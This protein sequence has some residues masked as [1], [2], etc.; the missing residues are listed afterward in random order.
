LYSD[1]LQIYPTSRAIREKK[2]EFLESSSFLPKMITIADFESR[3]VVTSGKIVDNIQ[4]A[5]FLK[6]AANFN[7][8]K[9][10]KVDTSLIKFYSH[11][12]EFFKFFQELAFENVDIKDLYLA[13]SYAWFDKDLDILD[14]LL[15]RYKNIINEKGFTDKIFLPK[16][17]K[18]NIG[19]LN[20]F[21][22]FFLELDGFLTKFELELF[23]KISEVK[24]FI[25]KI[26][27]NDFN[28]KVQDNFKELG[29]ILPNNSEI[30]FNLSTK[31]ILSKV[32]KD[33]KLNSEVI[34]CSEHLEQIAIAFSKIEDMIKGGIKPEKIAIVTPDES[35]A[36]A[37]KKLDR[38]NNINLAMGISYKNHYSFIV[39]KQLQDYLIGNSV[40]KDFLNRA[41]FNLDS[42]NSLSSV[43]DI[44]E[45]FDVLSKLNLP[46]Y[47][48]ENFSRELESLSL[49]QTFFKFKKVFSSYRFSFKD[50]LFLWID[51]IKEHSLDDISGG[52][53]TVLGV[54]ET[55]G[56]KFDGVV[57]LDFNDGIVPSISTKDRFLN[58]SVRLNANLPT[59]SDREN[60]QKNYY[61]KLL[62][63]AKESYIL[64]Q[65]N[66]ELSASKFLIELSLDKVKE[67]I[68]PVDMFYNKVNIF[69]KY[70][71]LEDEKVKF[72]AED[73]LWSASKLKM[74]L[75]CKRKFFYR[76]YKKIEEP[77]NDEINDGLILHN[78]LSKVLTK[79]SNFN[80]EIEIK[81]E[82]LIELEKL[83]SSWELGYKKLLW[84]SLLDDF[85]KKQIEH[86]KNGWQIKCCESYIEG[87][88]LGLKF[89]GRVDRIDIKDD[90]YLILDYKTGS[91]KQTNSSNVDK[92]NDFQ[93]N[94]YDKLLN[95]SYN[96]IDFA[97]IE[98]LNGGKLDYLKAK[99]DK[100]KKLLE[101]LEYLKTIDSF[102]ATRCDN[103]QMCRNCSYRLLCHRG[104]YL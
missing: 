60:L 72:K 95:K 97:Y 65:E 91:T 41:D 59:K 34:K 44:E 53:I 42:L 14:N 45:F 68:A 15:K 98:I 28:K 66:S 87:D 62:E 46:L 10:L 24:P 88:I 39:L 83:N 40:A 51:E 21:N 16:S 80:N 4:R 3:A 12:K 82:F 61:L 49:L 20:N 30:V 43:I 52:K 54:L 9:N 84:S 17:Y 55:R 57:I 71:H 103:L 86:F 69:N 8:F 19:Y 85:F 50:W 47:S 75:E 13:D 33:I 73:I 35:I 38:L 96:K 32:R 1:Y 79:N 18:L 23:S 26:E 67:Y 94:I 27:T 22:G 104:E 90:F 48:S 81:R 31:E 36:L 77:R 29:I 2:K 89:R 11:S 92:L 78:V 93:M 58:S 101:H 37:I 63:G 6:E 5:L 99:E 74:F 70:A 56:V 76:Y 7:D 64:Y 100:E 102:E 25:I